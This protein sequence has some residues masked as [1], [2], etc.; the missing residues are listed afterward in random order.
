[1]K[2]EE[3]PTNSSHS[4]ALSSFDHYHATRT[5]VTLQL[6]QYSRWMR[7]VSPAWVRSEEMKVKPVTSAQLVAG[8]TVASL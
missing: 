1:M 3:I 6:V 2:L 5:G 7:E 8:W 4:A